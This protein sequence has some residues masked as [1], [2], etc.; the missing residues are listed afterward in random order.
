ML[1]RCSGGSGDF[2]AE[3]EIDHEANAT[4]M[5]ADVYME[6]KQFKLVQQYARNASRLYASSGNQARDA[7]MRIL[8]V[9]STLN[10]PHTQRT[11]KPAMQE[12]DVALSIAKSLK[13]RSLQATVLSLVAQVHCGIGKYEDAVHAANKAI[14]LLYDD[15]YMHDKSAMLLF[16]AEVN[17]ALERDDEARSA[18]DEV[19]ALAEQHCD[20]KYV[21][22][23]RQLLVVL[24]NRPI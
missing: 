7:A 6:R 22:N 16:A 13:D 24:D 3:S 23:A 11:L 21:E 19:L 1:R 17:C 14:K 9:Q 10:L 8:V 15:K 20:D 12:A 2:K 18:V 5:V 4:G